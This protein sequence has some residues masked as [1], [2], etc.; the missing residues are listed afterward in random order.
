LAAIL[1]SAF[2][3]CNDGAAGADFNGCFVRT[4]GKVEKAE[5]TRQAE[6]HKNGNGTTKDERSMRADGRNPLYLVLREPCRKFAANDRTFTA[7]LL[8]KGMPS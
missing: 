2:P 6:T 5:R 4:R 3:I 1:E 7:H 8:D